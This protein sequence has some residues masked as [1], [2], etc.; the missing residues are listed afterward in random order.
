MQARTTQRGTLVDTLTARFVGDAQSQTTP[1]LIVGLRETALAV[2]GVLLLALSAR[3]II[4]LPFTPVPITGQTFAVLLIG[5]A[6][7]ARRGVATA[8]L[9][10]LAGVAGL[11][12][13][14][15]VPGIASFGYIGGFAL[16]A[17]VVGW[18]AERG[19][20]RSLPRSIV[21]ML[22]GE[23]AIYLC[24]LV[25]LARFVGW[26][27]VLALGL[28]PFLPGDGLKL[29]AAALI[30]PAA[31]AGARALMGREE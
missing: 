28:L 16:A 8:L 9:Y 19:W 29:C 3:V 30:L 14:A 4:P 13:F 21:A 10:I 25:W 12:V 15:A 5:A 7:G 20:D 24:G 6:Y 11:P 17:A 27:H 31:W 18:L 23:A 2:V 26:G 1:W 22:A